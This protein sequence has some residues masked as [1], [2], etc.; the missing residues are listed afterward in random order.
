MVGAG[1]GAKEGGPLARGVATSGAA[2]PPG[3]EFLS[4]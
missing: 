2:L 3:G 1:E 4:L